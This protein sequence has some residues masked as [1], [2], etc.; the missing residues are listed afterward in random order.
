[1]RERERERKNQNTFPLITGKNLAKLCKNCSNLAIYN[2]GILYVILWLLH[3]PMYECRHFVNNTYCIAMLSQHQV[4]RYLASTQ[5]HPI[6][7][8]ANRER[9]SPRICNVCIALLN[10]VMLT[11]VLY[12]LHCTAV[13]RCVKGPY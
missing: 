4:T 12:S 3:L 1:M 10:L 9:D 7:S 5:V 6:D 11:L 2:I 13:Y 8:Y